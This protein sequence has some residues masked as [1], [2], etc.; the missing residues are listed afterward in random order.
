MLTSE[1]LWTIDELNEQVAMALSVD[2]E[3]T[4]SGRVRDVPD[5]RT[6]R[7]YTT[8]GLLDRPAEMRGRRAFYNRRHLLQL[9]AVKRLQAAGRSLAEVQE[10]LLG[11]SNEALEPLARLPDTPVVSPPEPSPAVPPPEVASRD[12]DFW[13]TPPGPVADPEP[14][15]LGVP[16]GPG[17]TLLLESGRP[18]TDDDLQ[19]LRTVAAPLLHLLHTRGLS[20]PRPE[21][22]PA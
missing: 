4:A 10:R 15:L 20:A 16:L 17:V 8:L 1:P 22:K 9:V 21:R 12:G 13:K 19:A 3:G 18:P 11:L 14:V 2:Y 6:I 5:R 7:Y